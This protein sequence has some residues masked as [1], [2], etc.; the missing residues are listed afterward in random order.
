MGDL[1]WLDHAGNL[2]FLGR[3]VHRVENEENAFYSIQMESIFNQH[4]EVKRSALVKLTV[5]DK[6]VPGLVIER[7]D[8]KAR[9]TASFLRELQVLKESETFTKCIEHF[10]VHPKFPVDVR[11][12]IKID[13]I[14]LSQ[15]AQREL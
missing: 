4:P 3:K 6:V 10:F 9:L 13:R 1:G 14:K 2:W 15:W 7:K 11:H 5:K 8:G 12:N